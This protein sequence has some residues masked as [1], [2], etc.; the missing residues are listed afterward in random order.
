MAFMLD[1]NCTESELR[2]D[3]KSFVCEQNTFVTVMHASA[4]ST[5]RGGSVPPGCKLASEGCD[6]S[7]KKLFRPDSQSTVCSTATDASSTLS[8]EWCSDAGSVAD[9][10]AVGV[11]NTHPS[12]EESTPSAEYTPQPSVVRQRLNTN[13]RAF[14]PVSM[15]SDHKFRAEVEVVVA[16]VQAAM[17]TVGILVSICIVPGDVDCSIVAQMLPGCS[18]KKEFVLT[19]AK[20]ALLQATERSSSTYCMG[21][22]AKPFVATP[23]GFSAKLGGMEDHSAAC[24]DMYAK[25]ECR[26][27]CRCNR[28]HPKFEIRIDISLIADDVA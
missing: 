23:D 2:Y 7:L 22:R 11:T 16:A 27:G 20:K 13:A 12:N 17:V 19:V 18:H 3:D 15:S 4:K 5:R 10:P 14:V 6:D 26:R 25:G 24:W 9:S 28:E 8:E 1:T 21:Y